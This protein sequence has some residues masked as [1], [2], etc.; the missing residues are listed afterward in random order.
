[1]KRYPICFLLALS[2]FSLPLFG[3]VKPK[4]K[5]GMQAEFTPASSA[6]TGNAG[7]VTLGCTA[8]VAGP[9]Q[10]ND[11]TF[12]FYRAA[13]TATVVASCPLNL[14][15]YTILGTSPMAAS[16]S[17][18]DAS[19]AANTNYCYVATALDI[20]LLGTCPSGT[21][22]ESVP[23][24]PAIALV[25]P[26]SPPPAPGNLQIVSIT[27][28]N[29]QL[30]WTA[31]VNPPDVLVSYSI[32]DCSEAKC[33]APPRVATTSATSYTAPCPHKNRTCYYEAEANYVIG[34]EKI[35]SLPSN[36]VEAKV[37]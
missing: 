5:S 11:A 26:L 6:T 23:S 13:T 22:C 15:A 32:F 9:G 18:V 7:T 14:S 12:N 25:P 10:G 21:V 27:A 4:P 19:I 2:F 33:P 24:A 30:Q 8:G 3:Q 17:Y 28:S 29:V 16:C 31:P 37:E 1:M 20:Q 36:I 35:H 34:G